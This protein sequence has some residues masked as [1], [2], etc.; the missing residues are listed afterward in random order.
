MGFPNY[1][2]FC[3][4]GVSCRVA[5]FNTHCATMGAGSV[6]DHQPDP[7][8]PLKFRHEDYAP[9]RDG[10][11]LSYLW[12]C[13]ISPSDLFGSHLD[14]CH[15]KCSPPSWEAMSNLTSI[16]LP[17]RAEQKSHYPQI[18]QQPQQ[19]FQECVHYRQQGSEPFRQGTLEVESTIWVWGLVGPLSLGMS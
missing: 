10:R 17:H 16:A 12:R 4:I 19:G 9:E 8:D 3:F 5:L 7:Q 15:H 14:D 11:S 1:G 18:K 6:F 13:A 2:L